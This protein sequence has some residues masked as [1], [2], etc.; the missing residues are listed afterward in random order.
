M[1]RIAA[2]LDELGIVLPE[3]FPPS[4]TISV[5]H[6]RDRSCTNTGSERRLFRR[7][8]GHLRDGGR[9]TRSAVGGQL[10]FDIA[11]GIELIA[12]VD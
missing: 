9:L 5:A 11:L 8:L 7:P 2:R 12:E 3:L 6:D 4:A 10:P 1:P